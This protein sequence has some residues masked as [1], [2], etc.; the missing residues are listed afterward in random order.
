MNGNATL[1]QLKD[2][3]L[4]PPVGWWPPAPGWWLL[5]IGVAGLALA[6]YFL[7]RYFKHSYRRAA[8]RELRALRE[9]AIG[10]GDRSRLELLAA[11]LRRVAI[12]SC[13]REQVAPLSGEAWLA[14]LDRSGKTGQ[15]TTGVGR[16]LGSDLYRAGVEAD[17][18]GL[19]PLVESWIRRHRAC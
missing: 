3:H 10:L 14:F 17:L 8:L 16:A 12:R 2:I 1:D 9:N 19:F 13:G 7:R 11:L 4:P 5:L 18:Q 6:G 15:F